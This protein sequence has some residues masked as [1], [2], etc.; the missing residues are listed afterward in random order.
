MALED[1][2]EFNIHLAAATTV[3]EATGE[4]PHRSIDIGTVSTF[5]LGGGL[6]E[7]S[8]S[9]LAQSIKSGNTVPLSTQVIGQDGHNLIIEAVAVP[10]AD[11]G[12][13]VKYQMTIDPTDKKNFVSVKNYGEKKVRIGG[14]DGTLIGT[15]EVEVIPEKSLRPPKRYEFYDA[16][17]NSKID[18]T[19]SLNYQTERGELRTIA[20]SGGLVNLPV[21]AGAI[22]TFSFTPCIEGYTGTPINMVKYKDLGSEM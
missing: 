15:Y 8:G 6:L 2:R 1:P 17:T 9:I 16:V 11:G 10:A 7:S 20:G 18:R 21:I 14:P 13:T 12:A 5:T 3:Q 22:E 19:A 4:V